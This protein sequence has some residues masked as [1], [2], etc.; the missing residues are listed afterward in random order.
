MKQKKVKY[1]TLDRINKCNCL[2]NLIIGERSTGK[3]YAMACQVIDNY[4]DRG[5]QFGYFRR[6]EVD[7]K[8]QKGYDVFGNIIHN[9]YIDKKSKG[10]WN[11]V[12][13]TGRK[14]YLA[15]LV[16]GVI[17]EK[18][19]KPF[20]H[21]FAISLQSHYK[22]TG[23]PLITNIWFD[24]F[25]DVDYL[26]NEFILFT[27][28][29]SSIVRLEVKVKIYMLGNTI[30]KYSIYWG[31]M[32]L[33]QVKNIKCGE[34]QIYE[35][36]DSGLRVAVEMTDFNEEDKKSNVY[37]AFDNPKLNLITGKGD[38]WEIGN[39]PHLPCRYHLNEILLTYFIKFDGD[40][41]QCEI[42]NTQ[43]EEGHD[44]LFTYIHMKTTPIKDDDSL[45]YQLEYD[46]RP[47]YIRKI[48]R[49]TSELQRKIS[50]FYA[51]DK[52]FYQSNDVGEIVRNYISQC[53]NA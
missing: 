24:E 41:L 33:K 53:A 44:L 11:D 28:L 16:D 51:Q 27:N 48:T 18:D 15:R 47:N 10:R 5:E 6:Y 7:I 32:G 25:L 49:P 2:Y 31:E 37:F 26:P 39:Y 9:G 12:I 14:W 43:D 45:V 29:V 23:Y 1:Y 52:V 42:I 20:G 35:Y 19:D 3:S 34:I 8:G 13:Y 21:A 30:N 22:S 46:A 38:V 36:G 50:S 17:E 40:I 4:L